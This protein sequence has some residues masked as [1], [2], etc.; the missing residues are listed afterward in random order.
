MK[1]FYRNADT[2]EHSADLI[3][4]MPDGAEI[5]CCKKHKPKGTAELYYLEAEEKQ[6]G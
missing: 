5:Y 2:P 1:C 4:Y 3:A 6:W